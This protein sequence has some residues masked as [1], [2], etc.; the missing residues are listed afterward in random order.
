MQVTDSSAPC[1]SVLAP[2]ADA[3]H[4]FM[5]KFESAHVE[6]GDTSDTWAMYKSAIHVCKQSL[7]GA[8]AWNG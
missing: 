3:V 1:S 4:E 6:I 7:R 5:G 2:Y 8:N